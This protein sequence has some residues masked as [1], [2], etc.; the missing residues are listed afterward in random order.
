M[1]RIRAFLWR[2]PFFPRKLTF[3]R[4]GRIV[5]VVSIGLG[6]AAVNTGNNLIYL[7]FS[8]SLALIILSGILSEAN[9]RGLD[10][11]PISFLRIAAREA[12][13]VLLSVECRRKRFP[14]YS[15][16]AWPW[17]DDPDVV[18]EP[19]R[20]VEI[21]PGVTAPGTCRITG[22]RRG[23]HGLKGMVLSTTFPF[24]FFR[25]SVVFPAE[26]VLRVYPAL[27]P[28]HAPAAEVAVSGDQDHRSWPGR[29]YE[30]FGV[31]DFRPGDHPRRI[32]QRKSAG[33]AS[34]VVREDEDPGLKTRWIGLLNAVDPS[35]PAEVGAVEDAIERA[36][37]LAVAMLRAGMQVG[38]STASGQV[39]PATGAYQEV[40]ILDHL[41][42]I[43][44]LV[45]GPDE[46][47]RMAATIQSACERSQMV[48]VEP[49]GAAVGADRERSLMDQGARVRT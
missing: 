39:P 25:K 31:R 34:P 28:S 45:L 3:T 8:V 32:L 30:F 41:A 4:E 17:F 21:R 20:F 6:V 22:R 23:D 5:V 48:W 44:V 46:M 33:R 35:S 40:A 47:R 11:R 29:G 2:S 16:E 49:V 13:P 38:V 10:V 42:L 26:A 7:V 1:G 43:P 14:A 36:A 27:H 9:L 18:V 12:T 24:S 37:S 15:V 19:A